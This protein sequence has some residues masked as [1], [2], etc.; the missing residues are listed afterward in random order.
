MGAD[1]LPQKGCLVMKRGKSLKSALALGVV[2]GLN[3]LPTAGFAQGEQPEEIFELEPLVVTATRIAQSVMDIPADV[4]VV[5]AADWQRR[6]AVTLADALEGVP[7]VSISRTNGRSGQAIPYIAGTD[8]V[9]VLIDG[10]RMNAAQGIGQ[11]SGGVDLNEYAIDAGIID[12]IEVVRGG[13]SVLYGADAVGGVIQIFTRKGSAD[14]GSTVGVAFGDDGQQQYKL[15]TSG[16][17]E[18]YHWRLNGRFFE[19]DG[20][21]PNGFSR[22]RDV[23]FRFDRDTNGGDLFFT[24]DYHNGKSGFPGYITAPSYT[25]NGETTRRTVNLGYTKNDMSVQVYQN[26]RL[27][28]TSMFDSWSSVYSNY[29]YDENLRGFLYQDSGRLDKHHLLTW[30]IDLREASIES[31]TFAD[32]KER[33]TQAYFLQDTIN[34]GEKFIL[35]PGLRYEK[36][37]DFGDHWLPK[38]GAVYKAKKD[39]SLFAN[40]GEVFRAPSF[41]ELYTYDPVYGSNGN[42]NLEAETGWAFEIGAKKLFGTKHEVSASFFRREMDDKIAWSST[43]PNWWDPWMPMNVE[44]YRTQG[45]ILAWSGKLSDKF[46]MDANYTY[47]DTKSTTPINQPENQFHLGLHYEQGRFSQS[48][49][50]DA[51]SKMD[52]VVGKEIGGRAVF[53]TTSQY[54]IAKDQRVYLNIYNLFDKKYYDIKNYPANGVSF[55]LGWDMKF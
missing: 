12:R 53:S 45:V 9:V 15:G 8:Q 26:T 40:W 21:R 38:V 33:R 52:Q 46:R 18:K 48:V 30:G 32:D 41:D 20:F 1:L 3:V 13:G 5:R 54:Q 4:T 42:P 29:R 27:R 7:G 37:N 31:S 28:E 24:Y 35:T 2:L 50:M 49:M 17:Y 16:S 22:D 39:F 51:L 10:V 36:N 44:S 25:D 34:L 23:S 47:A 14:D 19:T 11:G 43:G 6:G 55:L